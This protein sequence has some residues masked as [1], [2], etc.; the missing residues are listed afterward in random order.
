MLGDLLMITVW[1]YKM[2]MYDIVHSVRRESLKAKQCPSVMNAQYLK[3]HKKGRN[4]GLG[5]RGKSLLLKINLGFSIQ[6]FQNVGFWKSNNRMDKCPKYQI[7]KSSTQRAQLST[8]T[9]LYS[10]PHPHNS[11]PTPPPK[12]RKASVWRKCG[13]RSQTFQNLLAVLF[14]NIVIKVRGGRTVEKD[15]IRVEKQ[16]CLAEF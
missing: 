13:T 7:L 5:E 3:Q 9:I 15:A 6:Q 1:G 16:E 2:Y 10:L 11:P 12:K 8:E 4:Q 14:S